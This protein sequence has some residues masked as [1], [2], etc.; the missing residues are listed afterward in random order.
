MNGRNRR[1]DSQTDEVQCVMEPHVQKDTPNKRD[2]VW[3]LS[4]TIISR[5]IHHALLVSSTSTDAIM[6]VP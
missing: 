2:I 3:L 5:R 4:L 6:L 1:T